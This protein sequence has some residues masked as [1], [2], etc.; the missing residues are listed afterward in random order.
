MDKN[1]Q[2]LGR[3]YTRVAQTCSRLYDHTGIYNRTHSFFL[4]SIKN[5]FTLNN[6]KAGSSSILN[7]ED[8]RKH[9]S[10][11]QVNPKAYYSIHREYI[12]VDEWF[13]IMLN[14]HSPSMKLCAGRTRT[15]EMRR[16]RSVFYKES[17]IW[18]WQQG[19]ILGFPKG[20]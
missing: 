15:I 6:R 10:R 8:Q 5:R 9:L 18:Q 16:R 2:I 13:Y 17:I 11:T 19:R 1:K 3:K 20:R 14:M 4:K 12:D 7:L